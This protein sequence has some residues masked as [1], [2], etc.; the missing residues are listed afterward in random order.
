MTTGRRNVSRRETLEGNEVIVV[1]NVV[2]YA[3]SS[4]KKG[5]AIMR[6]FW[7]TIGAMVVGYL[8]YLGIKSLGGK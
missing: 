4:T 8:M 7:V 5:G 3:P 6:E 1:C 2:I